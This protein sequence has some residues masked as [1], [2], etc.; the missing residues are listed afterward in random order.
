MIGFL[1]TI[2]EDILKA[3]SLSGKGILAVFVVIIVIMLFIILLNFVNN[4]LPKMK[5]KRE[6]AK[7]KFAER[8]AEI[9]DDD[10]PEDN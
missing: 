3:L 2:G 1:A 8:Y 4:G 9:G 5:E 7:K 6:L 10:E